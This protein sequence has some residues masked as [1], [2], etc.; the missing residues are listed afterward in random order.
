MYDLQSA[1]FEAQCELYLES[2]YD[3]M[4]AAHIRSSGTLTPS[5]T[6]SLTHTPTHS[7]THTPTHSLTHSL[8]HSLTHSPTHSLHIHVVECVVSV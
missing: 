6:H 2:P 3:E 7:L 8:N 1:D 4:V 5:L